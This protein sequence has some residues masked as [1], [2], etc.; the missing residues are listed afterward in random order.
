MPT[1]VASFSLGSLGVT[2]EGIVGGVTDFQSWADYTHLIRLPEIEGDVSQL[3]V[4]QNLYDD[5]LAAFVQTWQDNLDLYLS[6][7]GAAQADA[8]AAQSTSAATSAEVYDN[9]LYVQT[10]VAEQIQ[11]LR[12]EKDADI[13]SIFTY[14][15]NDQ[16]TYID[17]Q[18]SQNLPTLQSEV[19][20]NT[21]TLETIRDQVLA[22]LAL[23]DN[24]NSQLLNTEL[25]ATNATLDQV[26][27]D[28]SGTQTQ[29]D[30]YF[31]GYPYA[32]VVDG[33]NNVQAIVEGH[34]K[35]LG[36]SIL[37]LPHTA[38]CTDP[39][40][41]TFSPKTPVSTTWFLTDDPVFGDV[42]QFTD[43][44]DTRVGQAYPVEFDNDKLYK[45]TAS[46]R[47]VD[48]GT[49]SGVQLRIGATTFVEGVA[50]DVAV[51]KTLSASN[52]TIANGA[53]TFEAVFSGNLTELTDNGYQV[54]TGALDT[55]THLP[56]VGAK[57]K[58]FF[59]IRQNPSLSTNGRIR[60]HSLKVE[61]ITEAYQAAAVIRQDVVNINDNLAAG[62][63]LRVDAGD[64]QGSLELVAADDVAG[65]AS[66][67]LRIKADNIIMDGTVGVNKL[68]VGFGGNMIKESGFPYSEVPRGFVLN[69][70]SPQLDDCFY[71]VVGAGNPYAGTTYNTLEISQTGTESV[72]DAGISYQPPID[73]SGNPGH[74]I[75][76]E[77]GEWYEFSVR[78]S[79][80]K[81]GGEIRIQWVNEAGS[82]ISSSTSALPSN[83]PG[84]ATNPASWPVYWV[85]GQAP[86]S[87][88]YARPHIEKYAGTDAGISR[89]TSFQWQ[90]TESHEFATEPAPYVSDGGTIIDGSQII[91]GSLN[92]DRIGAGL[93]SVQY[94]EVDGALNIDAI[95]GAFVMGRQS[96]FD[97]TNDGIYLGRTDDGGGTLGFG[98]SIGKNQGTRDEYIRGTSQTGIEILNAKFFKTVVIPTSPSEYTTPT[99]HNLPAGTANITL[100]LMG[101]GG[102]GQAGN[103]STAGQNGGDTVI[104][105]YDGG[106]PTGISWTATGGLGGTGGNPVNTQSGERGQSSMWGTGGSPGY[107][108]WY[109]P[110]GED[111][112][113]TRII[114]PGPGTGYGAGGGGSY[115]SSRGGAGGKASSLVNVVNYDVSGYTTPSLVITI[116]A[117]GTGGGAS[118]SPGKVIIDSNSGDTNVVAD[119]VTTRPTATG[120]FTKGSSA[121]G[122][123]I[124][125]DLGPGFWI[126]QTQGYSGFPITEL[127]IDEQGTIIWIGAGETVSFFAAKR[128][129]VI[130][131]DGNSRTIGYAFHRMGPT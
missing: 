26:V 91:T 50:A 114:A 100:Q 115:G 104:E 126:L 73:Q 122:S 42:A 14:L 76:V 105:L 97:T 34:I 41:S 3:E 127:E 23:I 19:Q 4:K 99:T 130:S 109:D 39:H 121:T 40:T 60:L 118:G 33:L 52:I 9:F 98:F 131:S 72:G 90:F 15:Q 38:W 8:D 74:G 11:L 69:G 77:E 95:T 64:A 84:S 123:T 2:S 86:V 13:A 44:T 71:A 47:V 85:K 16:Q 53:V 119:V 93:M 87:A 10:H 25:P 116:G 128:P 54:G 68:A 106:V 28:L 117:G 31:T 66:S 21:T 17:Q 27:I 51:E 96:P 57:N 120:T 48:D 113:A 124:F 37:R 79:T 75:P 94:L 36:V 46:L 112:Y 49:S 55:A 59:Y 107:L 110:P 7:I 63:M 111:A 78:A 20:S 65:N 22:E 32:N 125:P 12:N 43:A 61:D 5:Q 102:G 62:I 18:V 29:L 89:I 6:L 30:G 56:A 70:S 45:V 58:A 1:G 103:S 108:E 81:C 129:N 80:I 67:T 101:G 24:A 82:I 83:T 88:A 35:S 92:A